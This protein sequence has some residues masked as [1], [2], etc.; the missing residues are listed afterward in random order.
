[1]TEAPRT[2]DVV[3]FM[4]LAHLFRTRGW[5]SPHTI[6]LEAPIDGVALLRL[7]EVPEDDVE[8]LFVNHHAVGPA[9][10]VVRPGDRVAVV[11]PGVPGPHRY[12]LGIWHPRK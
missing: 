1:M 7:L 11:P 2:I 12:G 3:G 5:T 8:C 9:D 6:P 10:A 4:D